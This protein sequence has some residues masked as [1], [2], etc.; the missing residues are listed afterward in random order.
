[1]TALLVLVKCQLG[2]TLTKLILHSATLTRRAIL[3]L[4]LYNLPKLQMS[5]VGASSFGTEARLEKKIGKP[6]SGK[7]TKGKKP[8]AKQENTL[9]IEFDSTRACSLIDIGANLLDPMFEGIYHGS[10]KHAPDLQLVLHRAGL[11]G[12]E[13]VMVTA[14]SLDEAKAAVE[15]VGPNVRLSCTVGVHPT[16]CNLFDSFP[17]GP[18]AYTEALLA[19]ARE[20]M[21]NGKVV[22]IG[23]CGLD[24]ARLDFCSKETQ[25]AHF[26]RHF[27]LTRETKLPL[28]LHCREAAAD[29][30]ELLTHHRDDFTS[31]V[32]HSFDGTLAEAQAFIEL[33]LYIGLNGCSLK[34]EQNLACVAALPR[35]RIM[36][37]TDSPWCE[38]RPTHA[39]FKFVKSQWQ[40]QKKEKYLCSDD[41]ANQVVCNYLELK[42]LFIYFRS[43]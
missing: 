6:P 15:F 41:C 11:V 14:G 5:D 22:A 43:A 27:R 19:V 9:N 8:A 39:A 23:E 25:R 42:K 28:F 26:V 12:V 20:G 37:E 13:H 32:V 31:G 38:I 3:A 16:R 30:L 2:R 29:L 4:R 7:H 17:S 1:M 35:D 21:T 36:L 33:G 18:E 24:Y 34:T 40:S 10:K